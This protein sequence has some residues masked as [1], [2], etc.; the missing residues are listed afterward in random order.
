MF[1]KPNT[2]KKHQFPRKHK[3]KSNEN[4][5]TIWNNKRVRTTNRLPLTMPLLIYVWNFY[6]NCNRKRLHSRSNGRSICCQNDIIFV[7][8]KVLRLARFSHSILILSFVRPLATKFSTNFI[9]TF[10]FVSKILF[11]PGKYSVY[12]FSF[13]DE[14]C[15]LIIFIF[16]FSTY[17]SVCL[18]VCL[19]FFC[20]SHL[21]SW[22]AHVTSTW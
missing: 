1:P 14:I 5:A 21:V 10:N 12:L 18:P 17:L 11:C 4:C 2:T 15:L 13:D 8:H 3:H 6:C 19:Q 16:T 20:S 7:G 22:F 9:R